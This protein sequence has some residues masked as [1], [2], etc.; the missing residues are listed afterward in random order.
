MLIVPS[1]TVDMLGLLMRVLDEQ[2]I[3]TFGS[4][5][6]HFN[7]PLVSFSIGFPDHQ[8]SSEGARR[9]IP[10]IEHYCNEYD[11]VSRWG[12]L[13]NVAQ[14]LDNRYSGTV[15]VR[16]GATGH[17]FNQ[18]YLAS[19][20]PLP[21]TSPSSALAD[22]RDQK[23]NGA[24]KEPKAFLDNMVKV[25]VK[26]ALARED[27]AMKNMGL[28]RRESASWVLELVDG[29]SLSADAVLNGNIPGSRK[30][31]TNIKILKDNVSVEGKDI[32]GKTVRQ[33]S[34][35]WRYEGGESPSF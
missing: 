13:H 32:K 17:M 29:E 5:A 28:M 22:S 14:V 4:A 33:L 10:H 16:I 30:E 21:S 6:S 23:T 7:N 11:M 2:E 31:A 19:M 12:A 20:F 27:T 35:L 9:C 3:Y 15:F 25:D 34:R 18:H 8:A 24:K 1:P 26:L